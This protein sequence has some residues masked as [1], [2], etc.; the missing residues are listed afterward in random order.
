MGIIKNIAAYRK[1]KTQQDAR[2]KK[3]A[4][5]YKIAFEEE[6]HKAALQEIPKLA[7]LVA[8]QE[9]RKKFGPRASTLE[10]INRGVATAE[11]GKMTA[12]KVMTLIFGSNT[13]MNSGRKSKRK[14]FD[15]GKY[16]QGG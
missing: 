10:R 12:G 7:K 8:K 13:T 16:L 5:E 3:Q 2:K 9:A 11:Q 15:Y 6:K 1:N 4:K 14:Q